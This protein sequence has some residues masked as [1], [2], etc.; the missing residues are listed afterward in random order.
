MSQTK[1]ESKDNSGHKQ[2]RHVHI[3]VTAD[4]S[5]EPERL[6]VTERMDDENVCSKRRRAHGR[7]RNVG[8]SRV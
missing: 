3:R 6:H 7:Q 5:Q 2:K 4:V 8:E 1:P